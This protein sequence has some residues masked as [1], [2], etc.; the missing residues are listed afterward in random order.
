M[1]TLK[2]SRV[3]GALAEATG[4]EDVALNELVR[5][6]PPLKAGTRRDLGGNLE[7]TKQ[8]IQGERP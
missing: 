5:Y 3:V 6:L 4:M 8:L 2:L 7:E 1:T